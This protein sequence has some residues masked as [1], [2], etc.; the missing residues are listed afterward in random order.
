MNQF[1]AAGVDSEHREYRGHLTLSALNSEGTR[2]TFTGHI[3]FPRGARIIGVRL[4]APDGALLSWRYENSTPPHAR[5]EEPW[6][7]LEEEDATGMD[8]TWNL[9]LDKFEKMRATL[10]TPMGAQA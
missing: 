4:Y 2:L 7:A 3:D 5:S 8:V 6:V 10:K 9:Y 1:I